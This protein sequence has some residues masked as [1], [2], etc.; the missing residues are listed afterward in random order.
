MIFL[1][2]RIPLITPTGTQFLSPEGAVRGDG[3]KFIKEGSVENQLAADMSEKGILEAYQL[4]FQQA[5]N[6]VATLVRTI[7]LTS[8]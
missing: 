5:L 1:L 3:K 2:H 7:L 8:L 4:A 6:E